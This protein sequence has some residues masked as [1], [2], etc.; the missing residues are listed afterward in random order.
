[1]SLKFQSNGNLEVGIHSLSWI[2]FTSNFGFNEHRKKLIRGLAL[3]IEH[4][5]AC[6]CQILYIDGSFVT[7]K[8]NPSDF[9]ACWDR[10]G[11]NL[12]TMR[13]LYPT[14]V[15]FRNE[16]KNQKD[17]YMGEIFPMHVVADEYNTFIDFFQLDKDGTSKGIVKLTL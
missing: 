13:T 14:L 17:L 8:T 9:D 15:D 7:Q 1:M 12:I 5:K 16:R 3:A 4:L 11:I 6:G 2:D 10:T